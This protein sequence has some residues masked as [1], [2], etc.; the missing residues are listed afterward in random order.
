M[1]RFVVMK[2]CKV[3]FNKSGVIRAIIGMCEEHYKC[4]LH[5]CFFRNRPYDVKATFPYNEEDNFG[6]TLTHTTLG[7]RCEFT[8]RA[9]NTFTKIFL[10]LNITKDVFLWTI[11]VDI[12]RRYSRLYV[13][14]TPTAVL[15]NSYGDELG[16]YAFCVNQYDGED[17]LFVQLAGVDRS[18][19]KGETGKENGTEDEEEEEEGE[20]EFPNKSVVAVELDADAH[21]LSFLVGGRKV[22]FGMSVENAPL[23]FG[24]CAV[25]QPVFTT[26][27]LRRLPT[28]V[29]VFPF[30][31]RYYPCNRESAEIGR[32]PD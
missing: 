7:I 17:G 21:T 5:P 28:A 2:L 23:H 14:A 29:P 16:L 31:C 26:M 10:D 32:R 27:S 24:A 15:Y 19:G 20:I 4:K 12:T 9:V 6:Y 1:E 25:H 18:E 11:Q 22:P 30:V 3:L 13:G 8:T